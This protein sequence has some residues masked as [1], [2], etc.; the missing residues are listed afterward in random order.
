MRFHN[1]HSRDSSLRK[2]SRINRWLIAGS[3]ALTGLFTEAAA[4]A[5]PGKKASASAG[6][7]S[8]A[9]K[10]PGGRHH[11]GGSTTKTHALRPPAQP[12]QATSEA[13]SPEASAPHE[14][15]PAQQPPASSEAPPAEERAPE[16]EPQPAPEPQPT[17]ESPPAQE[18]PPPVVSGGS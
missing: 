5:F 1:T 17:Q 7:A 18:S 3:V 14:S 16:P 15:A 4:L 13:A 6:K 2:L 10:R 12:P 9:N 11:S 8:Q